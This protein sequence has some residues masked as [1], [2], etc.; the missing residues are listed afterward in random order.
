[1]PE[2]GSTADLA[3]HARRWLDKTLGGRPAAVT[4]PAVLGRVGAIVAEVAAE[5]RDLAETLGA[6]R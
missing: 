3:T 1:V 5:L 6:D 4:D 2:E